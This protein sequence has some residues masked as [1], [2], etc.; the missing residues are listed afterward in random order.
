[1]VD[2]LALL[3]AVALMILF[4]IPGFALRK[5]G[6]ADG[7]VAKGFA[8]TI[9]YIT[10]PAMLIVLFIRPYDASIMKTAAW[11][12]GF[13]MVVH[14]FF[15]LIMMRFFKKAPEKIAKVSRFGAIFSN[16]GYMGIPVIVAALGN[17]AGIYASVYII[18]FNIYAWSLGAL[19]YSGDKKYISAKK[20][21]INPATVPI[22]IGLLF[23]LLPIDQYVPT[24]VVDGLTTLKETVAPMAMMLIGIRLA[25]VKIK[26]A[27]KDKWMWQTLAIRLFLLPAI[28]WGI[29]RVVGLTGW[30]ADITAMTVVLICASTPCSTITSMFAEKFD[31]E[32]VYASKIVSIST[33]FSVLTIPLVSL[34]LKI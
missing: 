21:F 28:A 30:F 1:M 15:Y 19:V 4:I 12:F 34:L 26:S 11:V 23:F 5:L 27:F 31:C 20:V 9:L 18:A 8:N 13:S 33:V 22:Y 10:Q 24:L 25:D 7:T 3:K 6:F 32:P 16:A 17:E 29:M 2:T 14:A